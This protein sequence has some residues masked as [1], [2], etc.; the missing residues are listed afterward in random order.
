MENRRFLSWSVGEGKGRR[1]NK[2]II[3]WF[4]GKE[5]PWSEVRGNLQENC[6][7]LTTTNKY[8]VPS[9]AL[10][11]GNLFESVIAESWCPASERTTKICSQKSSLGLNCLFANSCKTATCSSVSLTEDQPAC[12]SQNSPCSFPL[13]SN[14]YK[15]QPRT[16]TVVLL[17][18]WERNV[19]F[20]Y[21]S[22]EGGWHYSDKT[23]NIF[24]FLQQISCLV[25]QTLNWNFLSN[26][27]S[28]LTC[29]WP[30]SRCCKKWITLIFA[31]QCWGLNII[32]KS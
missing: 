13:L 2:L 8:I 21:T 7:F 30:C 28:Q 11:T 9:L 5:S 27:V 18:N 12:D 4:G 10:Q 20:L 25:I 29:L 23:S 32:Y 24:L 22:L 14:I 17:Q 26:F 6:I 16:P 19:L 15:Y 3:W 31:R 1:E